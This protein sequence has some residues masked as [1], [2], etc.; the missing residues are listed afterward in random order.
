MTTRKDITFSQFLWLE[1]RDFISRWEKFVEDNISNESDRNFHLS[2]IRLL[3]GQMK[4]WRV[5]MAEKR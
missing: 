5:W 3:K 2:V 4:A 1:V